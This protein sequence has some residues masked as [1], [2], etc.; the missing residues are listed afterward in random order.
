MQHAHLQ[1]QLRTIIIMKLYYVACLLI[2]RLA[3]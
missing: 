1:S 2:L 3:Y